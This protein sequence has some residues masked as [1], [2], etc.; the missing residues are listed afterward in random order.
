MSMACQTCCAIGGNSAEA[1][2]LSMTEEGLTYQEILRQQFLRPECDADLAASHLA[3]HGK[4]QH[5]VGQVELRA[6]L[7][8]TPVC[9]HDVSVTSVNRADRKSAIHTSE[10]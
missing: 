6:T 4:I 7:T 3:T 8:P 1:Y 5:R 10:C 2:G 9:T